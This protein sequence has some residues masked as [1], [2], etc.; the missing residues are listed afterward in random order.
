M[1]HAAV[2]LLSVRQGLVSEMFSGLG[3]S[4]C[5]A[6]MRLYIADSA[7]HSGEALLCCE[8]APKF[9][10][11]MPVN[12]EY[13]EGLLSASPVFH[14]LCCRDGSTCGPHSS[15]ILGALPAPFLILAQDFTKTA[16]AGAVVSA[17]QGL[18]CSMPASLGLSVFRKAPAATLWAFRSCES[19][20]SVRFGAPR[21]MQW[22]HTR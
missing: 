10:G 19:Q 7:V 1:L 21:L 6:R 14:E 13:V 16:V 12:V 22:A 15:S 20:S 5:R 17:V 18:S 3:I 11:M 4:S 9:G 8:N 2:V